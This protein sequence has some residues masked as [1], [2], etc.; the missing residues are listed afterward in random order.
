MALTELVEENT[1][2]LGEETPFSVWPDVDQCLINELAYV[3]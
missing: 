1:G 2:E 3:T